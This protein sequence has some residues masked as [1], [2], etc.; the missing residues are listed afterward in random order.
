MEQ[1]YILLQE[2]TRRVQDAANI[3]D[4]REAMAALTQALHFDYFALAH[5]VDPR[6]AGEHIVHLHNYPAHWA[7]YY[8][9]HALG[10]CDPVHRASHFAPGGFPW[11]RIGDYIDLTARDHHMLRLGASQGVGD[12]FTIP[13]RLE[14]EMPG[15]C[16]FAMRSGRPLDSAWLAFA[17]IAGRFAFD[18]ARR[19]MGRQALWLPM[20]GRT[21]TR[22]QRECLLW[23]FRGKSDWEIS[24]ILKVTEGTVKRHI[25]NACARY[26]VNKRIMLLAPTLLDGTFSI[27]EIYGYRDTSFGT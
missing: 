11:A 25:L 3:D 27:T 12:G 13:I 17:E 24:Q 8:A 19:L 21:L 16:T 6:T 26:R 15:S 10:I 1:D 20:L 18:G 14:G 23:A 22:C 7:D 4:Y 5:H 9:R 2:L